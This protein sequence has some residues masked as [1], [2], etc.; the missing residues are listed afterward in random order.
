MIASSSY[1][2]AVSPEETFGGT[3]YIILLLMMI[4]LPLMFITSAIGVVIGAILGLI[5]AAL[6]NVFAAG[7]WIGLGSTI[8]WLIIAG[9]IIIWKIAERA[10][11]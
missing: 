4:T 10:R 6:L 9:G 8:V 5:M 7:T 11:G 2:I 1:K 3:V